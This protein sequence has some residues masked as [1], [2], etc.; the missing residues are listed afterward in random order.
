MTNDQSSNMDRFCDEQEHDIWHNHPSWSFNKKYDAQ[1][2]VDAM[3]R[4]AAVVRFNAEQFNRQA[5][6]MR[7]TGCDQKTAAAMFPPSQGVDAPKRKRFGK[8]GGWW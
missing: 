2:Q 4:N 1:K 6:F 8:N 3:R 7:G 5:D